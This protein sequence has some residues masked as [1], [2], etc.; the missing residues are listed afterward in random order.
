MTSPT[1][2]VLEVAWTPLYSGHF[3][4]KFKLFLLQLLFIEVFPDLL[5]LILITVY[6][7]VCVVAINNVVQ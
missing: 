3:R 6:G 1:I 4:E 7:L 2:T 5:V